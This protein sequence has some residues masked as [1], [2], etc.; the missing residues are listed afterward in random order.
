MSI[1]RTWLDIW[2]YPG[3]HR[4]YNGKY[5]CLISGRVFSPLLRTNIF[6]L[7]SKQQLVGTIAT[8]GVPARSRPL[9]FIYSSWAKMQNFQ[10]RN[11]RIQ[12]Y[13]AYACIICVWLMYAWRTL[14]QYTNALVAVWKLPSENLQR[15]NFPLR[16]LRC[17]CP[18]FISRPSTIIFHCSMKFCQRTFNH[19][20]DAR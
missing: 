2:V 16:E 10:Q 15:W 11:P 14:Y 7:H 13:P 5:S 1:V 12:F 19:S 3:V 8:L 17:M 9:T 4:T 18:G 6:Q 20:R